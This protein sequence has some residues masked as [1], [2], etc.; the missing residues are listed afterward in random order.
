MPTKPQKTLITIRGTVR[1]WYAMLVPQQTNQPA[2]SLSP[3]PEVSTAAHVTCAQR[4]SHVRLRPLAQS[5]ALTC[6]V[7][8]LQ[9][10]GACQ[11][12]GATH[13]GISK[14]FWQE[15]RSISAVRYLQFYL[16][17]TRRGKE[18]N[19]SRLLC[20][21]PVWQADCKLHSST[22]HELLGIVIPAAGEEFGHSHIV[23]EKDQDS[24][25]DDDF[26]RHR[27]LTV[28]PTV[29]LVQYAGV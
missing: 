2:A 21:S 12:W 6:S 23:S 15:F 18:L 17:F 26:S 9:F 13:Q 28:V 16:Y 7:S 25:S 5:P 24:T 27:L 4:D 8:R 22:V 11:R 3:H 19:N 1:P 10:L 29:Y 14:G 20:Q